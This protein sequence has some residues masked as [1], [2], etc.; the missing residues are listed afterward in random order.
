LLEQIECGKRPTNIS[1]HILENYIALHGHSAELPD[2]PSS[3]LVLE[4][5]LCS[6]K[7]AERAISTSDASDPV[8]FWQANSFASF[9]SDLKPQ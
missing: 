2:P 1:C 7:P 6:E 5:W 8:S 4:K 3:E 9:G